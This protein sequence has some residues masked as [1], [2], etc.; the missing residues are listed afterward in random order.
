MEDEIKK[1]TGE[2]ETAQE[3]IKYLEATIDAQND[4][5]DN[6]KSEVDYLYWHSIG[7]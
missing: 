1:L 7:V 4:E 2:L 3:I 5:I 6:L